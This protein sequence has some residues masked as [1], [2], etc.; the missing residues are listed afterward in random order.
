MRIPK[1]AYLVPA[2]WW[3]LHDPSVYP[4]PETFAP[5]RFLPP[6]NEPDPGS[7]AFGYGRR[8]CPGRFFADAGLYLNIAQTLAVFNVGKALDENGK[9][10]E[11]DVKPGPGFLAY[12]G[13]SPCR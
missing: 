9:E 3:F 1:D 10:I 6:R 8:R 11:V 2:V 13:N 5:E 7:E 12:Q 4:D